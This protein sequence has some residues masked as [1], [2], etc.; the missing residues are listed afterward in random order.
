M[1]YSGTGNLSPVGHPWKQHTPWIYYRCHT[2]LKVVIHNSSRSTNRCQWQCIPHF[3]GHHHAIFGPILFA[4][5]FSM[6]ARPAPILPQ[7]FRSSPLGAARITVIFHGPWKLSILAGGKTLDGFQHKGKCVEILQALPHRLP[8]AFEQRSLKYC[9]L[10]LDSLRFLGIIAFYGQFAISPIV[11][12]YTGE[13]AFPRHIRDALLF[14][15][16]FHYS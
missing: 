14:Y 1:E 2:Y 11:G 13:S 3:Q 4:V 10:P 5:F 6:S 12:A 9:H 7:I 15:L 16:F 8:S